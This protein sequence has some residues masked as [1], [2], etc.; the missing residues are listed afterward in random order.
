MSVQRQVQQQVQVHVRQQVLQRC[1]EQRA[2]SR[3]QSKYYYPP[4]Q[5]PRSFV[6]ALVA[7]VYR[8]VQTVSGEIRP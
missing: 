7:D 2:E 4:F 1:R 6:H 3:E 5:G 8:Q